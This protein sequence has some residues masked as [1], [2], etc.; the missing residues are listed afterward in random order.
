MIVS[1]LEIPDEKIRG[2]CARYKVKELSI[3]GSAVK[4]GFGE[5]SDV[6]ILVLFRPD[7]RVGFIE[8]SRMQRELSSMFGREVD[9]VPKDGLKD[10]IRDEVL[11]TAKIIYAE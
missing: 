4:A 9:L 1:D 3:F 5:D 7:A 11:S 2:F 10:L 8:F 6:D